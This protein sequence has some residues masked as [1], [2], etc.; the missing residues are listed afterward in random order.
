MPYLQR[1]SLLSILLLGL[2]WIGSE[3]VLHDF[4]HTLDSGCVQTDGAR[5]RAKSRLNQDV[6]YALL[7]LIMYLLLVTIAPECNYFTFVI[8]MRLSCSLLSSGGHDF[9]TR[10][11]YTF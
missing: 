6:G 8:G 10:T 11:S 5:S 1:A 7:D 4:R 9:S 3:L 2:D